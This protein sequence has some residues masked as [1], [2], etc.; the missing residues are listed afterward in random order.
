MV[1]WDQVERL[2]G[3]GWDWARIAEDERVGFS[4]ESSGGDSGRQLRTLYYQRRSKAQRRGSSGKLAVEGGEAAADDGRPPLLLRVG[5]AILPLF[6][7]WAVLAF[8]FPSPVGVFVPWLALLVL[9]ILAAGLLIFALFRATTRWEAALRAPLAIG[10]VLGLVAAGSM[11]LVATFEGCPTLAATAASSEPNQWNRYNNPSWTING[12][13]VFFFYG[14]IACPYCSA[15]SWAM[16][17]AFK[18]FGT[19][20]NIPLTHSNPNDA[21]PNTPEV[22]FSGATLVSQYV[23]LAIY[24][25]NDN[26]QITTPALP[27]CQTHSLVTAYDATGTIPFVV[28]GGTYVHSGRSLVNPAALVNSSTGQPYT[29]QQVQSQVDAQSGPAWDVI[30]PAAWTLEAIILKLNGG[31]G[32][33]GVTGD[34]HVQAIYTQL[35]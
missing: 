21:Y 20:S 17:A 24:E 13:P 23:G 31:Q 25:G 12:A 30:S 32:P 4:A 33:S 15:S 6:G 19:L 3:K 11:A 2:R 29:P 28:L 10:I 26:S 16:Y 34:S 7:I 22:D 1:D 18:Q 27:T 8:L 9:T 35:K 14:S 5:Y